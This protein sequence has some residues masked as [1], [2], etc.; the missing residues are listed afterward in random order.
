[1][2]Y[3]FSFSSRQWWLVVA[4]W[5]LVLALTFAAG[6]VSGELWQR[7]TVDVKSQKSD[8]KTQK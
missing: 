2:S 3:E 6:F 8:V 5:L 1:M 4:G 7:S